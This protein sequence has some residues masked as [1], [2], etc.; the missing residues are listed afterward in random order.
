MVQIHQVIAM[1]SA[2][3]MFCLTFAIANNPIQAGWQTQSG[4][5]TSGNSNPVVEDRSNQLP[6]RSKHSV[7]R[8]Q[9]VPPS[10]QQNQGATTPVQ[11]VVPIRTA[12]G[13]PMGSGPIQRTAFQDRGSVNPREIVPAS[14]LMEQDAA[15][16]NDKA[17]SGAPPASI[18]NNSP[19]DN[20]QLPNSAGQVWKEYD[21]SPYTSQITTTNTPQ[22]AVL[23]WILRETGTEMWFNEPLGI[24]SANR[25]RLRVYHT[26]E[27]HGVVKR[28]VD[29]LVSSRGQVQI[30]GL[31]LVTVGNPNW[32]TTAFKML[33]PIRVQSAGVQGWMMSKENAAILFGQLR[34]RGDFRMIKNGD[35]SI[36]DGQKL[37][38]N[39]LRPINYYQS[40]QPATNRYG[41]TQWQPVAN[42]IQE[43][44]TLEIGAMTSADKRTVEAVLKCQID[45]VEK[46]QSVRVEVPVQGSNPQSVELQVP[47]LISWRLKERFRWPSDQVLLLSCGVIATPNPDGSGGIDLGKILN[48]SRGRADALLFI[49][50]KGPA[51]VNRIPNR[52]QPVGSTANGG[53]G[54]RAVGP[55]R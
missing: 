11:V 10:R 45:Q 22:Q 31:K 37:T 21:I 36:H 34:N 20:R 30:M 44:F 40:I 15:S 19:S 5:S 52:L 49:E 4:K 54:L 7:N 26:P 50:Y 16:Q 8:Q 17:N 47:Q 33:Q 41:L 9:V 35:L 18:S 43:G 23:D 3:C 24:L 13:V 12:A 29:Q 2:G 27:I 6:W 1:I 14:F 28:I 42:R 53:G 51:Q 32:R 25:N 39:Q 38:V 48:Q 46:L 55:R